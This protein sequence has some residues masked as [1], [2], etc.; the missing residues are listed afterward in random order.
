M[1]LRMTPEGQA[2][3]RRAALQLAKHMLTLMQREKTGPL[4]ISTAKPLPP[5]KPRDP[6]PKVLEARV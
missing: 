4:H 5:P 2:D 3:T 1:T 6:D